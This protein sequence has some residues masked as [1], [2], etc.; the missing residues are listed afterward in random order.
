MAAEFKLP[1]L[2]EGVES[3]TVTKVAVSPGDKVEVDQTV[4]ELETD[5]ATVEVPSS[6]AG[7]VKEVRVNEGDEIRTGQ[8]LLVFEG[9]AESRSLPSEAT[10]TAAREESDSDTDTDTDTGFESGDVA[11]LKETAELQTP[12]TSLTAAPAVRR[13]AREIGVDLARVTGSGPEGRIEIDDVKRTAKELLQSMSR[14]ATGEASAIPPLPDFEKWGSVRREPM[15]K[16][17]RRVAAN[18]IL[19]R[20]VIPHVTQCDKA[21]VTELE[22]LRKRFAGK[23]EQA[24]GKLT[25]SAMLIKV[26]ASAL[27]V[28]PKFNASVDPVR[29]EIVYKDYFNIGIA[30]DTERGLLVVVLREAHKMNMIRIATELTRLADSARAGK[31]RQDDLEGGTF[32]ISNVG[33]IGGTYFTPIVNYPEVAILGVGRSQRESGFVEGVCQPRTMLPLSLSYDHRLIDGAEAMRF[34]RWIVDAI[35]EPLLLSLEG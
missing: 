2:A 8:V 1:E 13:F 16:F 11:K 20:S 27:K 4:L 15:T 31:I 10:P 9:D 6:T 7:I 32:T 29:N 5:K 22:E 23:A 17:R 34:L 25:M 33:S 24:G 35:E 26:V 12:D 18:M 21:D 30:V 14:P 3:A 19:S 28:F